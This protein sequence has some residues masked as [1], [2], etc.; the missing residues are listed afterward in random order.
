M[1]HV[2]PCYT[3]LFD[4]N[5]IFFRA[6]CLLFRCL[7]ACIR[8]GTVEETQIQLLRDFFDNAEAGPVIG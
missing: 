1:V 4:F 6:T 8:D 2:N 5:A 3:C 7:N